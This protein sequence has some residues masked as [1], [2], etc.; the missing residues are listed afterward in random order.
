ML[1]QVAREGASWE[2]HYC[3]KDAEA[4]PFVD[5][6]APYTAEQVKVYGSRQGNR[7][8]AADLLSRLMQPAATLVY[9]CGPKPL[10]DDVQAAAKGI[11]AER[12]RFE[13]FTPGTESAAPVSE[14]VEIVCARAGKTFTLPPERSLLSMLDE[15]RVRV[16]RSCRQGMCGAC[17]VRV[18]EGT[19]DHRDSLR[20]SPEKAADGLMRACVSRSKSPRLVLDL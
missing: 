14:S 16:R 13:W 17:E 11:L 20:T 9:S 1:R 8:S 15:N 10:M 4:H 2:L 12:V 19:P 6:L 5:V 18:L 7:L 3:V